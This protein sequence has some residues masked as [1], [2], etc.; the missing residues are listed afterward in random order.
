MA[1]GINYNGILAASGA[2]IH[3][4][5]LHK[6]QDEGDLHIAGS[7][8][9]GIAHGFAEHTL[10][11]GQVVL[12]WGGAGGLGSPAPPACTRAAPR[13]GSRAW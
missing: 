7:D 6:K 2:P 8:A 3:V 11:A 9:S 12:T 5:K 10:K 13:A 4:I 1:A